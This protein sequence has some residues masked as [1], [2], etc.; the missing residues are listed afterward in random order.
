MSIRDINNP[1][2]AAVT[3]VPQLRYLLPAD[4]HHLVDGFRVPCHDFLHNPGIGPNALRE[5]SRA[6]INNP[7]CDQVGAG[8]SHKLTANWKSDGIHRIWPKARKSSERGVVTVWKL[9]V[10]LW[11]PVQHLP[12]CSSLRRDHCSSARQLVLVLLSQRNRRRAGGVLFV[13]MDCPP[14]PAI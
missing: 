10:R 6:V 12:G 4:C 7:V 2:V 9:L 13:S 1:R 8:R 11:G 5:T 14:F 3:V